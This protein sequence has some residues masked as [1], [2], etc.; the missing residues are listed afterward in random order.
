[1][2][3]MWLAL[4]TVLISAGTAAAQIPQTPPGGGETASM[5]GVAALL[6]IVALLALVGVG[7]KLYDV[8]RKHDEQGL[9][10][11]ARLSDALLDDPELARLP[12]AATVHVPFWRPAAAT[13]II[14]GRVVVPEQRAAAMRLLHAKVFVE[15]P[16]ARVEDRIVVEPVLVHRA[17]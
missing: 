11:Q 5:G 15:W 13:V 8:K 9:H 14:S 16:S 7:V 10:L 4:T 2:R 1:M 12:L 17:A 6:V 3:T